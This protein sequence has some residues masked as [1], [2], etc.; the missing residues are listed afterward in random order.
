MAGYKVHGRYSS[1]SRAVMAAVRK[2]RGRP[3]RTRA[4]GKQHYNSQDNKLVTKTG[5]RSAGKLTL[6]KRVA[7]LEVSAKKHTDYISLTDEAITWNGTTLVGGAPLS[8]YKNSYPTLLAVQGPLNNGELGNPALEENEQRQSDT[9]FCTSVNLK[10]QVWGIRPKDLGSAI[11]ANMTIFGG[12]KM[13]ELCNSIITITILQ[14]KRPSQQN[15]DGTADVNLLPQASVGETALES[16][17]GH[18]STG[19][20]LLQFFGTSCA[21]K[22]YK[23]TR[24]TIVHQESIKTSF[25]SP[26][27]T[28]DIT[29]KVNKKLKFRPP[30]PPPATT[31]PNTQPY[32]YNL[33]VFFSVVTPVADLGW[34]DYLDGPKLDTKTARMYF[35]DV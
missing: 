6:T 34:S 10:G 1:K 33:A 19:G 35:K 22:S 20:S 12:K 4:K 2:R 23:S 13:E 15:A 32:N 5:N 18:T 3:R 30:R 25:Q 21:L 31:N 29:F 26:M 7:Q 9:I 17:Y 11:L 24:F 27:R 14:D 8:A 28:F 16:I